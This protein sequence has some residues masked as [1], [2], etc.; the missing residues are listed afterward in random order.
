MRRVVEQALERF[1][2]RQPR[3]NGR[4]RKFD[5]QLFFFRQVFGTLPDAGP[6]FN[7]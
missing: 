4:N 6:L 5:Q 7:G 2:A 3:R 1:G